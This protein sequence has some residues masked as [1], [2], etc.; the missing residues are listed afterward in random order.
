MN[1]SVENIRRIPREVLLSSIL[2]GLFADARCINSVLV[3]FLH[4]SYGGVMSSIYMIIILLIIFICISHRRLITFSVNN[5]F[6]VFFLTFSYL[7]TI[8]TVGH[9]EV[10]EL[11]F[12][13][14]TICAIMLPCFTQI[15]GKMVLRTMILAPVIGIFR[16]NEIF[17]IDEVVGNISMGMTYSFL[18]PVVATIVYLFTGF[19][20]DSKKLKIVFLI[21]ALI[22][23]VF[24]L[25]MMLFGSRGP[26]LAIICTFVF[27]LV[28]KKKT[29]EG[30]LVNKK[31][32]LLS[33]VFIV[34]LVFSLETYMLLFDT[35]FE[36][37]GINFRFIDKSIALISDDNLDHGRSDIAKVI[38]E[39]FCESPIWGNGIDRSLA[40]AGI[41]FPHNF[42]LQILYDGGL[43]LFIV[44]LVPVA[45]GLWM[46]YKNSTLS[47]YMVLTTLFFS[48]V[49][50]ALFSGNLWRQ[51]LLWLLMGVA[52]AKGFFYYD[53][54]VLKNG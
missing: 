6:I 20:N 19:K 39:G 26:I 23:F 10:T 7:L 45:R 28:V 12:A 41:S 3:S 2:V 47:S 32:A 14:F 49:P 17:A 16:V 27:L 21:C 44:L 5:F 53:N 35:F 40:N 36:K 18:P 52:L 46:K 29:G 22:N 50:G 25:R 11:D 31:W 9:P 24:L 37:F 15:D 42:I 48:S 4:L 38:W 51:A 13:V 33:V 8:I 54:N 1:R 34:V 30:V 43:L